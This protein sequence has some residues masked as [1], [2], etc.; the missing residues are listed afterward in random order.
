MKNVN[1]FL[2]PGIVP[3]MNLLTFFLPALPDPEATLK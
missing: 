3:E 1:I 2:L